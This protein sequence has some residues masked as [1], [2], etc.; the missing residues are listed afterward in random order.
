MTALPAHD[1]LPPTYYATLADRYA[2]TT[3]SDVRRAAQTYFHPDNLVEVWVG[4]QT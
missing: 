4:P 3:P 2:A 1:D